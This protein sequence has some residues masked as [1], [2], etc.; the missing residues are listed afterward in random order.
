MSL[1]DQYRKALGILGV[2]VALVLLIACANVAN[3]KMAQSTTRSRE[4]ALRVSIGAGRGRLVQMLLVENAMLA[5]LAAALGALF[6]WQSAPL[7]V[8]MIQSPDT[9]VQ[10]LLY[11]GWRG[12]GFGVALLFC[13]MLLFGVLPALSAS[14]VKPVSALKSGNDPHSRRLMHGMIAA[15]VAFCFLVIFM[16]G[17][18]VRAFER[19]SNKPLGLSPENLL[20][21]DVVAQQG[22]PPSCGIKSQTTCGPSPA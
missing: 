3:L 5:L 8:T 17:L 20:L 13:V 9:P 2:L 12:L 15:Q 14:A 6:A 21:M 11:T 1:Q 18:F 4:M 7:V 10:L 22:Y 16:S 19:L